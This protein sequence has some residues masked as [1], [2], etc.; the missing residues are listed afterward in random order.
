MKDIK[1]DES[2]ALKLLLINTNITPKEDKIKKV[3]LSKIDVAKIENYVNKIKDIYVKIYV[4]DYLLKNGFSLNPVEVLK[5]YL[6]IFLSHHMYY[7]TIK[8]VCEDN[9]NDELADI[10]LS[11]FLNH[12]WTPIDV[13]MFENYIN[14]YAQILT[15]EQLII[16]EERRDKPINLLISRVYKIWLEYNGV[17]QVQEN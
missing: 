14:F 2:I 17:N 13:Q 7:D 16:F 1:L 5:Q 12:Q 4:S 6:P 3:I 8:K 15:E 9:W 11:S 10:F